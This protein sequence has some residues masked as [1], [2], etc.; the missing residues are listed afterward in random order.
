M[1]SSPDIDM[2][3]TIIKGSMKAL[4][5]LV[6]TADTGAFDSEDLGWLLDV[7]ADR[8]AALQPQINSALREGDAAIASLM[9]N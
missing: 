6:S 7:V 1:M 8:L 5:G 4:S 3:M 9:G 2:E